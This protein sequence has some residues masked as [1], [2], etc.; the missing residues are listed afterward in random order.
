MDRLFIEIDAQATTVSKNEAGM[1]A[2]GALGSGMRHTPK[3]M[4][5]VE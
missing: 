5:R 2:Y 3:K 1:K 4:R